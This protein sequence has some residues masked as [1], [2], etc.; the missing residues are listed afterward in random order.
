MSQHP[1]TT[2]QR[3]SGWQL[4]P[5]THLVIAICLVVWVLENTVP[6][7]FEQVALSAETGRTQ[8]WRFLTSAFAHAPGFSEGITHIGFNML[9]L[10]M[11]GRGLE[12][13]FGQWRFAAIYLLSALGG[14]IGF[15]LTCFPPNSQWGDGPLGLNWYVGTVGASGA[16]FGLFGALLVVQRELKQSTQGIWITLLLNA[17]IVFI[18]PNVAW[19]AHVAGFLVGVAAT[20]VIMRAAKASGRTRRK[21]S[22]LLGLLVVLAV[23]VVAL[24][25]KYALS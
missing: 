17:G 22:P 1:T 13:F 15:V 6:G 5:L 24:V 7:F 2:R 9:A 21:V 25:V 4:A 23:L 12:H 20:W 18:V 11:V 19:Q 16:V 8:P 10:W 3:P 14:G